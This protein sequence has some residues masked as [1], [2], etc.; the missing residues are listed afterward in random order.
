MP[1]FPECLL[2]DAIDCTDAFN[3]ARTAVGLAPFNKCSR[4]I[5]SQDLEDAY[6]H[7]DVVCQAFITGQYPKDQLGING[8]LMFA[9]QR[10]KRGD[11]D[12]AVNFFKRGH[13][14]FG[15]V[16]PVFYRFGQPPYNRF[17]RVGFVGL[18][19]PKENADIDCAHFT[20]YNF[21]GD[22]ELPRSVHRGVWCITT[23]PALK[24]GEVP[25]SK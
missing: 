3:A 11:C 6:R 13:R 20:C 7:F 21:V 4:P 10:E 5:L 25:L 9:P 22:E 24:E 2:A 15:S 1:L 17:Q 14:W 8:T 16:P 19:N 18:Y 23:P 12:A